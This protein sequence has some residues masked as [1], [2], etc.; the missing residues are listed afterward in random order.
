MRLS[1]I[2]YVSRNKFFIETCIIQESSL[3]YSEIQSVFPIIY[4][5]LCRN[6]ISAP[7]QYSPDYASTIVNFFTYTKHFNDHH[8]LIHTNNSI[9]VS[10]VLLLPTCNSF[11]Q[12]YLP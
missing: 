10:E 5:F 4:I 3:T 1:H 11:N 2:I 12:K 7:K 6:C 8:V 9:H